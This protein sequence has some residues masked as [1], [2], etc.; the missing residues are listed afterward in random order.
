MARRCTILF[1]L[2]AILTAARQSIAEEKRRIDA[3]PASFSIVDKENGSHWWRRSNKDFRIETVQLG[4]D[5]DPTHYLFLSEQVV[6]THIGI[7]G[8][9]S[10]L[11]ITAFPLAETHVGDALWSIE[12][13]GDVWKLDGSR[14]EVTKYGCC[15]R[16]DSTVQ[17]RVSDGRR[18]E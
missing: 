1:A 5:S 8:S 10:R 6:D 7:E 13:E 11:K 17:F 4:P 18:I 16:P 15:D 3:G 14:I 12:T 9:K 2:L